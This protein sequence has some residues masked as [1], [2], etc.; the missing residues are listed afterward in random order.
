MKNTQV[1]I[2]SKYLNSTTII[3]DKTYVI[4]EVKLETIRDTQKY[5]LYF[6]SEVE[7]LPLNKTNLITLINAFGT[8]T[9]SWIGKKVRLKTVQIVFQGQI[10]NSTVVEAIKE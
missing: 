6:D 1:K 5:V 4:Q 2:P 7:G 10:K 9:D 8:D 3:P